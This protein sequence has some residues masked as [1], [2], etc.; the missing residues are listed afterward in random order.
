MAHRNRIAAAFA[1]AVTCAVAGRA[2]AD[3]GSVATRARAVLVEHCARCHGQDGVASKGVF[4]LDRD[5]LVTS[6][7]VAPGDAGSR[8]LR[9]VESDAMPLGG[10]PLS[11]DEKATLRAW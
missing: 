3:D 2:T 9:M 7:A 4:V 6:G 11:S 8:L 1:L 5:R 10:P